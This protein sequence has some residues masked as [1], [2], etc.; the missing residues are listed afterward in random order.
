MARW[1]RATL[2]SRHW[3]RGDLCSDAVADFGFRQPQVIIALQ[4]HPKL[5][6]GAKVARQ[7]QG[8]LYTHPAHRRKDGRNA[9]G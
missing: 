3:T 5:G 2:S 9:V 6:R 8:G 1:G 7:P 4:V